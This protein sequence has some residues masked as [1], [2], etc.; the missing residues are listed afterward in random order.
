MAVTAKTARFVFPSTKGEEI[1]TLDMGEVRLACADVPEELA[2]EGDLARISRHLTGLGYSDQAAATSAQEVVDFFTLG[3]DCLWVAIARGHLWWT[4]ADPQLVWLMNDFV[5]T[6][7]CIRTP[8][9]GWK[10]TDVGGRPLSDS[11]LSPR[12][13]EFAETR[14]ATPD[15]DTLQEL[16]QLINGSETQ[17]HAELLDDEQV[18]SKFEIPSALF[19][20]E[21]IMRTPSAAPDKPGIYTWWFD[22][23]PGVPLAGTREQDGFRLAY[24][25]IASHRPGT[26]RPLRRRLRDHCAGPVATSTLRRSLAAILMK[27]LDLHPYCAGKKVKLPAEEEVRLSAWLRDHARVAWTPSTEP[28]IHERYALEKGPPLPLNVQGN[29]HEFVGELLAMRAQLFNHTPR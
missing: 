5:L 11:R 10:N 28:W 21:D 13:I 3:A 19:K 12:L 8:I 27:R 29:R 9:G 23:L 14:K 24:V 18:S 16:L 6:G 7:E 4:F 1:A 2:Q 17:E 26:R 22:E 25:G 15:S 20:V